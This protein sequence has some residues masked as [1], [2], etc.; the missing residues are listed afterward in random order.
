[1]DD[2]RLTPVGVIHS[3]YK[4]K[5]DAP[6]QGRHND[7]TSTLEVFE[8]FEPALEDVETCTHLIVLYFQDRGDRTGLRTR[9]P[10]GPD[11]HGVFATRSPN[12][13]NPV[14]VCTVE[15]VE[16]SGRFLEVRWLDALDG[17]P[18][19][20]IKPY[21]AGIDAVPEARVGWHRGGEPGGG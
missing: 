4:E 11:A 19:I 12:R 1:M 10:W 5:Q 18:L 20:D 21:S 8:A 15:L 9:T 3:P 13:P 2:Y 17:S 7:V 14:G 6:F 16:R